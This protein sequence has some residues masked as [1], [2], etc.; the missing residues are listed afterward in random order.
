[1]ARSK[2]T[3]KPDP[4]F[5]ALF[6]RR[7]SKGDHKKFEIVETAIECLA[8]DG[9]ENTTFD[10]IGAKLRIRRSHVVYYFP[11]MTDLIDAVIQYVA[12]TAQSSTLERLEKAGD[13]RA[14]IQAYVEGP[15]EWCRR[16]PDHPKVLIL[17]FH[18]CTHFP[19]YRTMNGRIRDAGY[20]RILA[21]L[22]GGFGPRPPSGLPALAR[23]LQGLITSRLIDWHACAPVPS[24]DSVRQETV[25]AALA[26]VDAMRGRSGAGR[27]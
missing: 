17:F 4:I 25:E 2:S 10:S 8:K 18:L 15:F 16:Y 24:L 5:A 13:W 1:M 20:R 27:A 21:I 11:R 23:A 9:I 12:A 14:Q 26:L 6:E 3:P 19:E 22:E 7:L